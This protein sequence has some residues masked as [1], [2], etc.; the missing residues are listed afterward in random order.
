[1]PRA[2]VRSSPAHQRGRRLPPWLTRPLPAGRPFATT[3]QAVA[4]SR[5]TT[6]CQEAKCPNLGEC[7]SAGT[8]TFMVLGDKC[9]R[10]CRFCSVTTARPE[11]P[12]AD[13]P[14]RLAEA[15][16][17]LDLGHVVVTSVAR[18]DLPDHGAAHF[19]ECVRTVRGKCPH[20]TVEVLPADF[21]A[22]RDCIAAL[23]Q[24]GPDI[25]NH[26]IETVERL[27]PAVRPQARYRRSLRVLRLVKEIAPGILTKSG[28]MVGLG[29]T[30]DEILQTFED[31]RDVGCDI[32]TVGQY[33]QPAPDCAT[34][35]R[36]YRP[37]EF[38]KLARVAEA[39]GFLSVASGPFVRSS[40]NAAEL[41]AR[42]R[43][44]HEPQ[45]ESAGMPPPAVY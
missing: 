32:L 8:A 4:D 29:E 38:G 31:L 24:A 35:A 12:A 36:Y 17:R 21:R 43:R 22:R 7:W 10:R 11:A 5:V 25:Y 1:M 6:V 16:S 39:L 42:L 30:E 3:R 18:D 41:F 2:P 13:E 28:L 15:A 45:P 37:E 19:A 26:N 23:C 33:L 14:A 34:V 40:Y 44:G 20:A 9:T 27:T